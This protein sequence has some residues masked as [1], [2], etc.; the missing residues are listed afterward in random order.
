MME[1][2]GCRCRFQIVPAGHNW[3]SWRAHLKQLLEFLWPLN[4]G[5][6]G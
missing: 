1:G 5:N 4:A 2:K 6:T 3:T